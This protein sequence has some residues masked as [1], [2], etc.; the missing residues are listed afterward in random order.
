MAIEI[1]AKA[2]MGT[3]ETAAHSQPFIAPA[4]ICPSGAWI[5]TNLRTRGDEYHDPFLLKVM[6]IISGAVFLLEGDREGGKSTLMKLLIP[7][8][9]RL[10][11]MTLE[12][13]ELPEMMKVQLNTR[14][15]EEGESEYKPGLDFLHSS[16][17]RL[18]QSASFNIYDRLMG[19]T[20]FDNIDVTVNLVESVEQRPVTAVEALAIMVGIRKMLGSNAD[21]PS[22]E[23]LE[24]IYRTQTINDLDDYYRSLTTSM[25][26]DAQKAAEERPETLPAALDDPTAGQARLH[27]V[28]RE[29]FETASARIA[30]CLGRL[31]RG[32]YGGIIGGTNSLADVLKSPMVNL[33]WTG[34][35]DKALSIMQ[36]MM[37][38]WQLSALEANKLELIPNLIF[39][40]EVPDV[41]NNLMFMR[42][43]AARVMKSRA[44]PTAEYTAIQYRNQIATAGEAGSVIRGLARSILLGVGAEFIFRQVPDEDMFE[45]MRGRNVSEPD[46]FLTTQFTTGQFGLLY[47]DRPLQ[48]IQHHVGPTMLGLVRTNSASE[49]MVNRRPVQSF[50]VI[51]DR[52]ERLAI[53][54][55][56]GIYDEEGM[57][58]SEAPKS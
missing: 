32:D 14:K 20:E 10:Q 25:A 54:R 7:R 9:M 35:N 45:H 21:Q 12:G 5:G 30:I 56:T 55:M 44:F 15:P 2:F 36:A 16:I 29:E 37:H 27:N 47:P 40:E 22:P 38:R 19:M 17:H 50:D 3:P 4:P 1:E 48:L 46:I 39:N 13:N 58:E 41:V 34:V 24:Q 43:W 31:M 23:A 28:T 51:K 57:V 8:L 52:S 11:A 26:E 42:S 18:N 53:Q 33:D 49:G 6:G